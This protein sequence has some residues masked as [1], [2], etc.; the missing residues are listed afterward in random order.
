MCYKN[1]HFFGA[2]CF[3]KFSAFFILFG[4]KYLLSSGLVFYTRLPS[5]SLE[6]LYS[7]CGS[8]YLK[9]CFASRQ[10]LHAS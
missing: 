8:L 7:S 4:C 9:S 5:E 10:G 6:A 1:P 2:G 3:A